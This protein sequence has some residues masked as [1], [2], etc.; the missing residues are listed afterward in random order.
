MTPI[1]LITIDLSPLAGNRVK[2]TVEPDATILRVK[3]LFF[4]KEGI[5]PECV[6]LN[7]QD[8][9]LQNHEC[10][11]VIGV[12]DSSTL[13]FKLYLHSYFSQ[14]QPNYYQNNSQ[15]IVPQQ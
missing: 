4:N 12:V 6:K 10:L 7:F 1:N 5:P 3:Q 13:H 8:R 11:N 2:I 15:P 14:M 9:E